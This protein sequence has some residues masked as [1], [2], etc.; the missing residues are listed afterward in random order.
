[1]ET[2]ALPMEALCIGMADA[3]G[4]YK[5]KQKMGEQGGQRAG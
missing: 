5:R 2:D 4:E 3:S 1:M